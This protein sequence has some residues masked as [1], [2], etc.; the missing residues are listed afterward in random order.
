VH[1][2][3]ARLDEPIVAPHALEQTIPRQHAI[4][5]FHQKPPQR[6]DA[7]R[8][9]ADTER[10]RDVVGVSVGGHDRTLVAS[11]SR[12]KLSS[13][14]RSVAASDYDRRV[15]TVVFACVQN[16]GRSQMAAAIF[17]AFADPETARA[18]SA[19]TRPADRVHAEVVQVMH[20]V[21]VDLGA[22]T[23]QMLNEAITRDA[24]W[25]ITMG[26]GEECPVI[27]G[28]RRDDWPIEDPKGKPVAE[29]RRIREEIELR[30]RSLLW[31]LNA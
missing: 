2:D 17:N 4:L 19:G 20:E 8:E 22:A 13:P 16:A 3:R 24:D 11:A 30:V 26:C 7:R 5:V 12:R 27:P 25:L 6:S 29:V 1:I 14:N 31:L 23:P 9:L 10:L 28:V 18:I 21:G 15:I